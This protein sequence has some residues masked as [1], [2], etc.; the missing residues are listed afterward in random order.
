[1]H[2]EHAIALVDFI[3]KHH[4]HSVTVTHDACD[5]HLQTS[6]LAKHA[7]MLKFAL[8]MKP[9]ISARAR[10]VFAHKPCKRGSG[11]LG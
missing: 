6:E 11:L 1:M 7:R 2:P 5:Q 9:K 4:E 10:K 8:F 3:I